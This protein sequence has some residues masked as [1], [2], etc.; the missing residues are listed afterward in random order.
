ML[1]NLR[2][3]LWLLFPAG[4]VTVMPADRHAAKAFKKADGGQDWRGVT[5]CLIWEFNDGANQSPGP[6][7]TGV[8]VGRDVREGPPPAVGRNEWITGVV[9]WPRWPHAVPIRVTDDNWLE[10]N[11]VT[12]W[13]L[14]SQ[15][16]YR[17]SRVHNPTA[18]Y[19]GWGRATADGSQM[20]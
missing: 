17:N 14:L 15:G 2:S 12:L 16:H 3:H 5:V 11:A 10:Q 18:H 7:V 13:P 6:P 20:G 1:V 8:T 4:N 9:S 19:Y